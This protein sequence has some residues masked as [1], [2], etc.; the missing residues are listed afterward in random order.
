MKVDVNYLPFAFV[1][2]KTFNFNKTSLNYLSYAYIII[3]NL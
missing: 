1:S 3:L 2:R